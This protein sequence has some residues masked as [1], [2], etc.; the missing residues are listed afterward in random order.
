M[1][2]YFL[3]TK[4]IFNLLISLGLPMMI[5]MLINSLYN[6]IDSIYVSRLG[7][8]AVTALS[9]IFPL[10]NLTVA[11]SVGLGIGVNS[12]IARYMGGEKLESAEKAAAIGF[13]LAFFHFIIFFCVGLFLIDKYVE[14]YTLEG[15][16]TYI[17][18][19]VYGR[20]VL[21]F[22]LPYL[23]YLIYEKIYQSLGWMIQAMLIMATGAIANILLDPIMI[24]GYFGFPA[25]GVAGAA[26]ATVLGQLIALIVAVVVFHFS[27]FPIKIYF[28]KMR[29]NWQYIKD[30]YIVTIPAALTLA[31]PSFLVA[32]LNTIL[33]T[34]SELSI[35]V[36]G[37]YYKIQTFFY[38]P[39]SGLIQ[40]MRPLIS[41][42][43][44]AK[45]YKRV[46]K[47]MLEAMLIGMVILLLGTLIMQ[48]FPIQIME[49]FAPEPDLLNQG[50]TALRIISVGFIFS[51]IPVVSNGVFEA[52][53]LGLDSLIISILRQLIIMIPIAYLLSNFFGVLGVWWAFPVSEFL[54][55]LIS[56]YLIVREFRKLDIK[57]I[58]TLK[59]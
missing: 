33:L 5:S 12:V 13:L 8:D 26:I 51:V 4:P 57:I 15:T 34:F 14:I 11:V 25:L 9:I 20:I 56:I 23:V 31:L 27:N 42:N 10:Q 7:T 22:S 35:A 36:L 44:G 2:N 46:S 59:G 30:I 3:K 54:A 40:G 47:T 41:Y 43:Y 6:I 16:Q 49:L 28:R 48:F 52:L 58:T 32:L 18:S 37:L 21:C 50:A 29:F 45:E 38:M 53:G 17:W 55:A 1:N 24:F 39:L 19:V